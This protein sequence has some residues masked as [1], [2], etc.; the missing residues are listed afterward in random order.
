MSHFAKVIL[1]A[2]QPL[3]EGGPLSPKEFLH[4]ASRASADQTL[5]RLTREGKLL[6]QPGPAN[7]VQLAEIPLHL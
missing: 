3:P 1:S 6:R 5:T 7:P 2:A 4:L